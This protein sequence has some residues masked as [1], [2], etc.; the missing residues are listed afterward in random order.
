MEKANYVMVHGVQEAPVLLRDS[1]VQRDILRRTKIPVNLDTVT[2]IYFGNNN[3]VLV[4]YVNDSDRGSG[5]CFNDPTQAGCP[6]TYRDEEQSK[7]IRIRDFD[8]ILKINEKR[9]TKKPHIGIF[10]R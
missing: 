4:C 9:K 3:S 5:W 6:W 2:D 10:S 7:E 1:F 8:K